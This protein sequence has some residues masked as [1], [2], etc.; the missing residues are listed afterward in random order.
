[1]QANKNKR[2]S[3]IKWIIIGLVVAWLLLAFIVIPNI[4]LLRLTLFKD[5]SLDLSPV[6]NVLK[7]DRVRKSL[8]N[9]LLIGLLVAV[10]TNIIGI[11]QVLVL[12]YFQV[13]GRKWLNLMYHLPL[14]INGMVL[15]L[16]YNYLIGTRGIITTNLQKSISTL[17]ADWFLGLPA[18]LLQLTFSNTMYHITFVRAALNEI[19][20]QTV[21]AARNMGS[22]PG[23]ILKRVV[24]P[25]ILPSILAAT[26]L[27]FS[28]GI[29][30]FASSKIL[31]GPEFETL[32]PLI[33]TFSQ[34]K[35]TKNYA[36]I[37]SVFLAIATAIVLLIFNNIEKKRNF[38]ATGKT[39]T[40]LQRQEIQNPVARVIVTIFAHLIA[41][42]QLIPVLFILIYSFMPYED[43][44]QGKINPANFSLDNYKLAFGSPSGL[45]PVA[46][47]SIYS[48]LG[49]LISVA[50]VVLFARWITK[51]RNK[52]TS[53][54]ESTVMI[55]W[56]IPSTLLALGYLFTFNT[57]KNPFV[58][59]KVLTGTTVILLIAYVVLRLP[60]N[61][62]V[63]KAA[64]LSLNDSLEEASKNMGASDFTTFRRVIFPI[65][66]PTLK[67]SFLLSFIGLFAEFSVTVFLFHPL[68]MPLG[69][70]I[71]NATNTEASADAVVLSFV[72]AIIIMLFSGATT[73][74]VYGRGN[75]KNA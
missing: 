11:F 9:S 45:K 75:K 27:N 64:F 31:G 67:S 33:Y 59:G 49:A 36:V 58:F 15:V 72:Y 28:M 12:D 52:W 24:L 26:I 50:I 73:Y 23:R 57:S 40:R 30:V 34:S 29:T 66:S 16:S 2:D 56:F 44:A 3:Y 65:L 41:I 46:T 8:F 14:I 32:N 71:N 51:Y 48:L 20:Y 74:L 63:I 13:K 6:S 68:H 53:A 17:P 61:L 47:S 19:D 37:L 42:I 10:T 70:V 35:N 1:M 38:V 18:V 55:P 7:S 4:N 5:G 25:N 21:E 60:T 62:R 39:R 54:L 43:L 69:I 22:S